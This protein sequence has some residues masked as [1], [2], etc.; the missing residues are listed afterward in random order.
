MTKTES[1][2]KEFPFGEISVIVRL[3]SLGS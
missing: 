2:A 1:V 3:E